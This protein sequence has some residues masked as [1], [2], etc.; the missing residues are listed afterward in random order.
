M[1]SGK[2]LVNASRLKLRDYFLWA[3]V[4]AVSAAGVLLFSHNDLNSGYADYPVWLTVILSGS[5][6]F[7][8]TYFLFL[9]I[10][11]RY[12]SLR[13]RSATYP[14][15][16]PGCTVIVPAYN[17]SSQVVE[18]LESIIN[19]AY[20]EEK[21][22]ILTVNDGSTDDTLEHL[23]LA[24]EKY[25]SR[26]TLID[27]PCNQ[28]K[29]HALCTA[30]RQAEHEFIITVDSDS[31][32]GTD[33]LYQLLRPFVRKEVGAVAGA[34]GKKT[35]A[36][37]FF[38]RLFD[39]MLVFGCSL[40]RNAQ[41]LQGNVFCTP[42]A[43]SAYRKSAIFPLLETW[44]NQ[45]FMGVPSRIGEDR[46]IATL[47]LENRWQIEYQS[48]AFAETALPENYV[49]MCRMLLRWTRSDIRENILMS[50]FA[51]RNLRAMTRRSWNLFIHWLFLS[52][53][54]LLPLLLLPVAF[55]AF[56]LTEKITVQ[57]GMILIFATLWSII[58]A[59]VYWQH[60]HSLRDTVW[61]FICGYFAQ[62]AL[63]WIAV[64][65]LFTLRNSNWL[66][67]QRPEK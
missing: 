21:M 32:V 45:S 19:S 67:R 30:I 35:T 52:V 43:L 58:P 7:S 50:Q 11:A 36:E 53:N 24:V 55:T 17:E 20:P 63:S 64:Y 57:L 51:C 42:G 47:L 61:A 49:T 22:Q 31:I 16:Y 5:F 8:V 46:A 23:R 27:L 60:R 62:A 14:E 66:T 10:S 39:V 18:T 1:F 41:S 4:F 54:M 59:A 9:I 56:F 40:L 28:G 37:N 33:T 34:I 12:S 26:L 38:V 44:Q 15:E 65:S 29:K 48:S 6:L 2:I 13:H 25:P 3:I